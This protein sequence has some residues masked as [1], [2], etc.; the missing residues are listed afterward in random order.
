MCSMSCLHKFLTGFS[1]RPIRKCLEVDPIL[2]FK[3][4]HLN[5]SGPMNDRKMVYLDLCLSHYVSGQKPG[6]GGTSGHAIRAG[7]RLDPSFDDYT[8]NSLV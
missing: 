4:S 3:Y 2:G 1:P 8:Q 7:R 6:G 5:I